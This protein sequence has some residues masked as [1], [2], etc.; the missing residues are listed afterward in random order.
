M[1]Y[2]ARRTVEQDI[3]LTIGDKRR[4]EYKITSDDSSTF[5][6]TAASAIIS[7]YNAAGTAVVDA[8]SGTIVSAVAADNQTVYY[9]WNTAN[10]L[11]GDYFYTFQW[12]ISGETFTE[13]GEVYAFSPQ[14]VFDRYERRIAGWLQDNNRSDVSRNINRRDARDAMIAALKEYDSYNP[15][16]T[17]QTYTL[18]TSTFE[19]SLPADYVKRFSFVDGVEYP[20][21]DTVQE[22]TFLLL[23]EFEVDELRGMW[24]FLSTTP[25]TGETARLYYSAR[26]R[27]QDK[28][29][30]GTIVSVG[31][32]V[33][34]TGTAFLTEVAIG[35]TIKAGSASRTV[36][37]I[38]D[39]DTLTVDASWTLSSS[40]YTIQADTL[41]DPDFDSLTQYAAGYLLMQLANKAAQT[42]APSVAAEFVSYRTKQQ[43]Y[44]AQAKAMMSDAK[45]CWQDGS[46]VQS[47][48]GEADYLPDHGR[49]IYWQS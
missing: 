18:A 13:R 19:Y 48:I 43:E 21:D 28:A 23:R 49:L 29:G 15:R 4:I 46:G 33:T 2:T 45:A 38:T 26:N 20:V 25:A 24:R 12:E 7:I 47:A 1:S 34:G 27:L 22:R 8:A 32:T 11:P 42:S 10:I 31:T 36:T 40:A 5:T 39:D 44:L 6:V 16:K 9:L 17:Y 37:A 41:P 14:S 30:T 3:I 35:D